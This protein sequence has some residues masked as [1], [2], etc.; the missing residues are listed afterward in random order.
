MG[1]KKKERFCLE[2]GQ[3][4]YGFRCRD[5]F[6][7]KRLKSKRCGLAQRNIYMRKRVKMRGKY[8]Y[9]EGRKI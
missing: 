9:E 1:I 8:E 7:G 4:S 5:C 3:A 6:D 2:C